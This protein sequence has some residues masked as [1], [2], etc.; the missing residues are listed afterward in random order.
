MNFIEWLDRFGVQNFEKTFNSSRQTYYNL[1]QGKRACSPKLAYMIVKATKG[2]ISYSDIFDPYFDGKVEPIL[3]D[4]EGSKQ[5]TFFDKLKFSDPEHI[6][7]P[8]TSKKL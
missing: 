4:Q 3:E 2:V 7:D 6:D 5:L 8:K 1:L